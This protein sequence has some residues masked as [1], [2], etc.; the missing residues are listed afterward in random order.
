MTEK[1][2]DDEPKMRYDS[3]RSLKS[4]LILKTSGREAGIIRPGFLKSIKFTNSTNLTIAKG[5]YMYGSESDRSKTG[6]FP[7]D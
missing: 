1:K 4:E 2:L 3:Q 5:D 7:R 6:R